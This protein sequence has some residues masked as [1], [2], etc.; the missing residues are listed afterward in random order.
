M[1]YKPAAIVPNMIT[2]PDFVLQRS[3]RT[4]RRSVRVL[5]SH[6]DYQFHPR[7]KPDLRN[8]LEYTSNIVLLAVQDQQYSPSNQFALLANTTPAELYKP[9][10]WKSAI[11]RSL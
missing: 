6:R 5:F 11:N 2:P 1:L 8:Q 9:T 7:T 3:G 4:L 10:S